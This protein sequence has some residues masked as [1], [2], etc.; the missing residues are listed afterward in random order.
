MSQC[1]AMVVDPWD[2]PFNGTVVSTRRFVSALADRGYPVRVLT[3]GNGDGQHPWQRVGFDELRIPGVRHIIEAMRSPLARPDRR[4]LDEAL[5]DCGL[6]HVQYPF[7]LGHSAI[8]AA[9]ARSIP[10]L[11]S[12]HVQP[13]NILSNL[14]LGSAGV[15]V[16]YRLFRSRFFDRA[17][18][19]IAP[20]EFA[21]DLLRRHGVRT[22][23]RV[24]SNGVPQRFFD[25]HHAAPTAQGPWRILSVGRL[26]REK[27]QATLIQAVA[28]CRQRQQVTVHLAGAGPRQ[29]A[30]AALA[31]RLGVEA[32]I[33]PV[34]DTTLDRRY[35]E[36]DL[37]VHCGGVELEGMS[38]MEAMA[39]GN[40]VLVSN[41]AESATSNLIRGT[42]T[43]FR[44]GDVRALAELLERWLADPERRARQ[45]QANRERARTLHHERSV[46][47]LLGVYA[48]VRGSPPDAAVC[49]AS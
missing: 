7:F 46:S 30:L 45:G 29:A 9:R 6:V 32:G 5:R 19:V 47:A 1:I 34:D 25:L 39:S 33:G 44:A 31:R 13:E 11:C 2:H 48:E 3:I 36:A 26:A 10:V 4:C 16:L 27:D 23:I 41:A 28:A 37:F 38:V 21:A 14:G 35:R 42:D 20:S 18:R 49:A 43:H 17:D 22:P 8:T 15:G 40:A 24:V 12:F